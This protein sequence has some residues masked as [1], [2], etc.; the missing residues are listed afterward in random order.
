M[1]K[2]YAK[3]NRADNNSLDEVNENLVCLATVRVVKT[4]SG[5]FYLRGLKLHLLLQMLLRLKS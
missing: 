3:I 1:Y 4:P 5:L 2:E